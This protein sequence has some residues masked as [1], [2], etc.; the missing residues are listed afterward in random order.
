MS[1]AKYFKKDAISPRP[2]IEQIK[3][4]ITA[5]APL[6]YFH[7]DE[8]YFPSSVPW[9]F[10][11]GGQL[12]DPKPHPITNDGDNLPRNG[13]LD[14]AFLDLPSDQ[15]LHDTVK[16]GSLADAVAY[17]HAKPVVTGSYTDIVIWL[18][19]PFNGPAKL[20]LG[21]FIIPLGKAG[22]HVSDWE[23]MRL[24]IDN[25]SGSL[26]RIYLS[27][28]CKGKWLEASEFDYKDGRPVLYASL[29][30]HAHYNAPKN[31]I[32]YDAEKSTH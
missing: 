30:N 1:R 4:M 32:Y 8:E 21:P 17:I 18:Y 16:K 27:Q 25:L 19:Y 5:F 2:T 22:Q 13:N 7:P 15:P 11:N 24:R 14:S 20:Q 12:F 28:H 29:H 10:K 3:T 9:F 31:Y 23:H 6:I 26:K